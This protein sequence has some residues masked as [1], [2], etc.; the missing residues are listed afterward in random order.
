[1]AIPFCSCYQT[2][3]AIY[4]FRSETAESVFA[5]TKDLTGANLPV[6]F[7]PWHDQSGPMIP[8]G[9]DSLVGGQAFAINAAIERDGYYLSTSAL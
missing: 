9:D 5:L 4:L 7:A 1:M 3:M 8:C 2:A 6:E